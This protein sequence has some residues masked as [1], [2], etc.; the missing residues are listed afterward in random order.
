MLIWEM[1]RVHIVRIS[2]AALH[3]YENE[4]IHHQQDISV[5]TYV[6]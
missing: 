3:M 4:N 6:T 5:R 1:L 2:I